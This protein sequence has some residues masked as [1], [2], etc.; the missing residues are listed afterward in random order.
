VSGND[1]GL[2]CHGNSSGGQETN[3][4]E[5]VAKSRT[6]ASLL[7]GW[8]N[9]GSARSVAYW[10]EM[11]THSGV[12]VFSR[13][14]LTLTGTWGGTDRGYSPVGSVG[15]SSRSGGSG[16]WLPNWGRARNRRRRAWARETRATSVGTTLGYEEKV[17]T[18]ELHRSLAL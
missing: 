11:I 3:K 16:G 7:L 18:D 12:G 4:R 10:G 9:N 5:G 8:R 14:G 13:G 15:W 17:D 2:E 6:A 1:L